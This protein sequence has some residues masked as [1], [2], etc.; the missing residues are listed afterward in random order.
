MYPD[1]ANLRA[2]S[3]HY[4]ARTP[5]INDTSPA[6]PH[7]MISVPEKID[8]PTP[9]EAPRIEELVPKP[10]KPS[11]YDG[12]E[13]AL[14]DLTVQLSAIRKEQIALTAQLN[15]TQE[16]INTM[17]A[18]VHGQEDLVS[19]R[20]RTIATDYVPLE[21][22]EKEQEELANLAREVEASIAREAARKGQI[23]QVKGKVQAKARWHQWYRAKDAASA[24]ASGSGSHPG[25]SSSIT[26]SSSRASQLDAERSMRDAILRAQLFL[27]ISIR[28][29]EQPL[30]YPPRIPP[31][32][33]DGESKCI[34]LNRSRRSPFAPIKPPLP[35]LHTRDNPPQG[36]PSPPSP[37]EDLKTP[38]RF[39][40]PPS[41][42]K[43][44]KATI[45]AASD[46]RRSLPVPPPD[47]IFLQ[48]REAVNERLTA[49]YRP[50]R[51]PSPVK[52]DISATR[53]S[54]QTI[55]MS[56]SGS[57][58][59]T[60]NLHPTSPPRPPS[61]TPHR[62]PPSRT[63]PND[64]ERLPSWVDDL[65]SHLSHPPPAKNRS[66]SGKFHGH[67]DS[68][69]SLR[70]ELRLPDPP[71]MSD[72]WDLIDEGDIS[73]TQLLELRRPTTSK[74]RKRASFNSS[75][76][77]RPTE[78]ERH[79]NAYG[80]TGG[81]GWLKSMTNKV[82]HPTSGASLAVPEGRRGKKGSSA[83]YY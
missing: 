23:L 6:N 31:E 35:K 43:Y 22:Y 53:G 74:L 49:F 60:P 47:A 66:S 83:S 45:I 11:R 30:K 71:P 39:S 13:H 16:A 82:T 42:F 4:P 76:H 2:V 29:S 51:V 54:R 5:M 41:A 72:E 8:P 38:G 79:T 67:T 50:R 80:A 3:H 37:S 28:K 64:E 25:S 26:G 56:S 34:K 19:S 10:T 21:L 73:P 14:V 17:Q 9:P 75:V 58:S 55:P 33:A 69:D 61:P 44:T 57:S 36:L 63:P 20:E 7:V 32:S 18:R 68:I 1:L 46:K 78:G 15:M 12:P 52:E 27:E 70:L 62:L 48:D 81:G 65:L 24:Q 59:S 40:T 77:A